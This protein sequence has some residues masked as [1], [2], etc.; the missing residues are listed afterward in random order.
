MTGIVLAGGR[1]SRFGSDKMRATYL[2]R[3][4]LIHA[5]DV[6]DALSDETFLVL[7]PDSE[8]PEDLPHGIRVARDREPY[9]GPLAG[10]SAGLEQAGTELSIVAGGDMPRLAPL[11]LAEMRRIAETF[12]VDAVALCEGADRRP[13]PLV[14]RTRAR[15]RVRELLDGGE[16]SLRSLLG[17]LTVKDLEERAWRAFDPAGGTLLDVDVPGQIPAGD[18]PQRS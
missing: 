13:L 11:L 6:L 3:P 15:D 10:L 18:D 17:T 4:L 8:V 16:R 7:A 12:D 9:G 1:S 2:G 5:I 14:L